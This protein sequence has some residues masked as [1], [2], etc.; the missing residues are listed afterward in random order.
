MATCYPW[1][2]NGPLA[3]TLHGL[4]PW[5]LLSGC[6][7]TGVTPIKM[8]PPR[9]K[10]CTLDVYT[11]PLEVRREYEVLCLIDST[12]G[13][14]LGNDRTVRGAIAEAKPY[15]CRCGAD[16]V[17][18]MDATTTTATPMAYGEGTVVL[19]AIRYV[20]RREAERTAPN[21]GS[22]RGPCRADGTCAE[23]LICA[24][25]LCV[26]M[27]GGVPRPV[28]EPARDSR[29]GTDSRACVVDTDCPGDQW[30][31]GSGAQRACRPRR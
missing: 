26:R 12:S 23:G 13:R 9:H 27:P 14:T 16:A 31:V 18:I 1:R 30:C 2:M 6:A 3:V 29:Q 21:Q 7:S 15:A 20:Q 11:S 22:E 10:N 17:I 8:A 5:I 28:A 24:S 25:G 19:R 4:L